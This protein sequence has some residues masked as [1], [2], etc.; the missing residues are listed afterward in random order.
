MGNAKKF[1]DSFLLA[2]PEVSTGNL[3]MKELDILMAEHEHKIN[4]APV[5]DFDGLSA[6]QMHNMLQAPFSAE[7]ILKY[8][9]DIEQHV[10]KVPLFKLSEILLEEIEKAGSLRLTRIG[11]LPTHICELLF[12]QRLIT[13]QYEAYIKKIQEDNIAYLWPLKQYLL[14]CGIVKKRKNALSLTK[15]GIR[16]LTAPKSERFDLLLRYMVT[17]FHWSNFY[18][19]I[20]DDE[21]RIGRLGWQ[22]SLALLAKYGD[23]PRKSDFY[24]FKLIRAFDTLL[25]DIY[26]EV[27]DN[28]FVKDYQYT[29]DARFFENFANWFGLVN[30]ERQKR[31][32]PPYFEQ[33]TIT[34]S[35]LFDQI[36][37]IKTW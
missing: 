30:I 4:S 33:L 6:F 9:E 31:R 12:H 13:L 5:D 11:N 3:N 26:Q 7:S 25:W 16:L 1:L 14:D 27:K 29:Y 34:K 36:F 37:E 23:T 24:N 18:E 22:Y 17:G 35:P 10:D 19:D 20:D 21:G 8:K 2:Y 28:K 32:I 15:G